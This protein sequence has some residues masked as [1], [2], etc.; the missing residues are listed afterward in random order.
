MTFRIRISRRA[1]ADAEA[2]YRWIAE[3]VGRPLDAL[4]W[5]DGLQDALATLG[6]RPLRCPRAPESRDFDR[7]VRQL[8]FQRHRVLFVVEGEDV[9]V[10]HIRHGR[11]LHATEADLSSEEF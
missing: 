1:E 8:F 7:E 2:M 5:L 4:R 3:D 10:L 11:R 9:V 6:E